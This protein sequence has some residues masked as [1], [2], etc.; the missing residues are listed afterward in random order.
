MLVLGPENVLC[1]VE[2]VVGRLDADGVSVEYVTDTGVCERCVLGVPL[3]GE[4]L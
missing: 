4:K 2:D 1:F 3:D